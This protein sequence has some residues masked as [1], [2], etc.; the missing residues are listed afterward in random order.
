MIAAQPPG[1]PWT[2]AL[3]LGVF[4]HP[5]RQQA[6][7][8]WGM[9][10]VRAPAAARLVPF[11]EVRHQQPDD[12]LHHELVA[13]RGREMDWTIPAHRHDGLHQFQLLLRGSLRG[14]VDGR[15]LAA[16]APVLLLLPPGTVHGFSY[17]RGASGHQVTLPTTTL[18]RL[19]GDAGLARAALGQ[20]VLLEGER[21]LAVR[22]Q[23]EHLFA[24]I[25]REFHGHAPGRV[26]SLLALATLLAVLVLRH[27]G[28]PPDGTAR[29]GAR[30]TLVQRYRALLERHHA[31]RWS[32]ADYA[33]AL[34]VT[35]DHLSRSCRHSTGQS[36]LELLH[37]RVLLEARRLLAYTPMPVAE[38]AAQLGFEDAAYFSRFFGRASGTSPS[39][40]R[41]Q[42]AAG[43]RGG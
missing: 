33:Q 29:P 37:E 39:Q 36:A 6:W 10:A 41:L 38:V 31:Q 43:V 25:A 32:L 12:C 24:S 5:V 17:T 20:P 35:A 1:P 14:E 8:Q 2:K 15:P 16:R 13:V 23:A 7:A 9:P 28:Q 30:D 21:A 26:Q 34:E 18:D 19:L 27:A 11:T 4:R 42:I 22:D 3:V 40:Y